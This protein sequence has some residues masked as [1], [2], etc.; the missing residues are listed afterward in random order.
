MN[1]H[2]HMAGTLKEVHGSLISCSTRKDVFSGDRME[3]GTTMHLKHP[4]TVSGMYEQNLKVLNCK[5][6]LFVLQQKSITKPLLHVLCQRESE[7][8]NK[9]N[10]NLN[11]LEYP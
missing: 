3:H 2:L 5:V 6:S 10:S 7:E 1:A 8:P 9:R 4:S 11:Q